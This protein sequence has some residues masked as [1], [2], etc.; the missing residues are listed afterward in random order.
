[1]KPHLAAAVAFAHGL[2][3]DVLSVYERETRGYDRISALRTRVQ[4]GRIRP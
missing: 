3:R 2:R 1:M 4:S